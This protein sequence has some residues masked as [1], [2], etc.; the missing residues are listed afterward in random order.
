LTTMGKQIIIWEDG[1]VQYTA[2]K[3][4]RLSPSKYAVILPNGLNGM[5]RVWH[6]R[7]IKLLVMVKPITNPISRYGVETPRA[8][9]RV[10]DRG[11]PSSG[12]G[13]QA[14]RFKDGG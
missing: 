11:A 5:W 13:G 2:K 12:S 7:G 1:T 9:P 6:E 3:V 10:L 4:T 14:P 8:T